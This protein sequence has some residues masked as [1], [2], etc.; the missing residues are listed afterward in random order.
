MFDE[1]PWPLKFPRTAQYFCEPHSL[2]CLAHYRTASRIVRSLAVKTRNLQESEV[3]SP[4]HLAQLTYKTKNGL[5]HR[6][7]VKVKLY[8]LSSIQSFNKR[9]CF[10]LSY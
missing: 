6:L 3:S 10:G 1:S 5:M 8:L 7:Y 9:F 4:F 2:P